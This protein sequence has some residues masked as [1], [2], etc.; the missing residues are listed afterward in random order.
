MARSGTRESCRSSSSQ[1]RS[2]VRV[3][4]LAHL[5]PCRGR[6]AQKRLRVPLK[7]M[8]V[9]MAVFKQHHLLLDADNAQTVTPLRPRTRAR[10]LARTAFHAAA[11]ASS[12][13]Q[14][15]RAP[16][17]RHER[18][19]RAR[20]HGTRARAQVG[21]ACREHF[22]ELLSAD[23]AMMDPE[24]VGRAR[25]WGGPLLSRQKAAVREQLATDTAAPYPGTV[26]SCLV[27]QIE[28]ARSVHWDVGSALVRSLGSHDN[29]A[30]GPLWRFQVLVPGGGTRMIQPTAPRG[31]SS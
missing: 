21:T 19:T 18:H 13:P 14:Y 25:N 22:P 31:H 12:P 15:S 26:R 3:T 17:A 30:E 1:G 2:A 5:V 20:T 11:H 9:A 7:T 28:L 10:T 16:P 29:R 8:R 4:R 6:A 24:V 27:S 23:A